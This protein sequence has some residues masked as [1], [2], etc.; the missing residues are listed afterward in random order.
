MLRH[1]LIS[2]LSHFNIHLSLSVGAVGR[3]GKHASYS[4]PGAALLV[5]APGGDMES[6][7]NNIV[8][9][10]GGGC[11]DI[12]IGT[13]FAA[14]IAAGVVAL[15][16]E[17]NPSLTWRDVQGVLA[18]SSQR[19]D[20]EDS[21]WTTNAAGV[22]HSYLYGF[23]VVDAT[24]AVEVA[25]SWVNYSA[26]QQ[27]TGES[28]TINL[29]VPDFPGDPVSSVISIE[30]DAAFKTEWATVYLSLSHSSRGDLDVI[31]V[32]PS[33]TESILHPG[34]RPEKTQVDERWKLS[35]VRNWNEPANGNWTLRIV[36]RRAGDIDASLSS[37]SDFLASW[38]IIVYGHTDG[39][40]AVPTPPVS[41]SVASP[42]S[43][44]ISCKYATCVDHA[45]QSYAGISFLNIPSLSIVVHCDTGCTRTLFHWHALICLLVC[46]TLAPT[47]SPFSVLD[48][49]DLSTWLLNATLTPLNT[50][51]TTAP[52]PNTPAPLETTT[53]SAAPH[54]ADNGP[55]SMP[56]PIMT[57]NIT[58]APAQ[59]SNIAPATPSSSKNAPSPTA[60]PFSKATGSSSTRLYS[61]HLYRTPC[62]VSIL[63]LVLV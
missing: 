5:T 11:Q 62:A 19:M 13:S 25:Q 30:A 46:A 10:P 31:L 27:I 59:T 24:T 45:I 9:S 51:L 1:R 3:D 40:G 56:S 42:I 53:Q 4:T 44:P 55:T 43:P 49:I 21:S 50:T 52:T 38:R 36:D 48:L 6:Y 14:P 7:S 60:S 63:F 29:T 28:G 23:G 8:A 32:S 17:A 15:I 47:P 20:A 34:Q 33:G 39:G 12:T 2:N 54:I 61:K 37:T 22:S 18:I 35:T 57:E 41:G 58:E 16:L 26:E